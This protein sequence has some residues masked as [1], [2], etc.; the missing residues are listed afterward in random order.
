VCFSA[1]ADLVGGLVVGAIGVDALR[2]IDRRPTHVALACLPL[3]L[4]AHQIDEAFVWWGLQGHVPS[5]VGRIA[6]WAYLVFAFVL[7]P[8]YVPAAVWSIERRGRLRWLIGGFVALGVV[9]SGLL[10][11]AMI[12]GPVVAELAS[13]H[14]GYSTGLRSETVIVGLYVLATCGSLV[15]SGERDIAIF[16]VVNLIAVAVLARLTLDGFASLWCAWAAVSSGV[17]AVYLRSHVPS[18]RPLAA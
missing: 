16:G 13:H 7:L 3:L 14:V 11:A 15:F 2:H 17:F 10:L 8:I 9:V 5:E 1:Q 18:T 12:R 6:T 4:A